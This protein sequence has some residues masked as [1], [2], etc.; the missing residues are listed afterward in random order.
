MLAKRKKIKKDLV[1]GG[2]VTLL[3][4]I[5]IV[6]LI[7]S[8]FKINQRRTDLKDQLQVLQEQYQ[9]LLKQKEELESQ[10]SQT[11]SQD[12]LEIE[13]REN[14]NLKKPGE[15]VVAVL[16]PEAGQDQETEQRVWWN[17]FT[18]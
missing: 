12:Y 6:F 18:W 14:F 11:S 2:I 3:V 7:V 9:F 13:A 16:P 1:F 17:P 8:N 4:F 5:V 15:E 10:T